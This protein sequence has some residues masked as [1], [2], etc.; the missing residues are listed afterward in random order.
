MVH[1]LGSL[2]IDDLQYASP[3]AIAAI[4]DGSSLLLLATTSGQGLNSTF[5][6]VKYGA[7][8]GDILW[9]RLYHSPGNDDIP[10]SLA[11]SPDGSAVFSA[12]SIFRAD[13]GGIDY[14]TISYDAVTGA[15]GW[16]RHYNGPGDSYDAITSIALSPS[17]ARLYVTGLS[18]GM[19]SDGD[20]GTIAYN[21]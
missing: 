18:Y 14:S 19:T 6:T 16:V 8:T 10:T 2:Q 15:R 3:A 20:Y 12:G 4:P 17:G 21:S 1:R 13:T 11:I 5:A 9:Q 7:A